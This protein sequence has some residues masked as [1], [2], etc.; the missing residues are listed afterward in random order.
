M[1]QHY[2]HVF[3]SEDL[4]RSYQVDLLHALPMRATVVELW[5]TP[6]LLVLTMTLLTKSTE[7]MPALTMKGTRTAINQEILEHYVVATFKAFQVGVLEEL[8]GFSM[9]K[10]LCGTF[11]ACSW[12]YIVSVL[13]THVATE[14]EALGPDA[15]CVHSV[16]E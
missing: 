9:K 4:R 1:R 10:F 12:E 8:R 14:F 5:V 2:L 3:Y 13:E 7:S 11:N 6:T 15:M 16:E